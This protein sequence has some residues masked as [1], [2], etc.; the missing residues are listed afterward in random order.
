MYFFSWYKKCKLKVSRFIRAKK[1]EQRRTQILRA[2]RKAVMEIELLER[3]TYWPVARKNIIAPVAD[4]HF[5]NN[6][7]RVNSKARPMHSD[8]KKVV[9]DDKA[10]LITKV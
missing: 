9:I 6:I 8:T 5:I 2:R 10:S 3:F 4:L 7:T 1:R